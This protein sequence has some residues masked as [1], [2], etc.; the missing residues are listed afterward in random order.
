[1][2]TAPVFTLVTLATTRALAGEQKLG[3]LISLD[4]KTVFII[5]IFRC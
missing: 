5:L 2:T 1:M 4:A 3:P